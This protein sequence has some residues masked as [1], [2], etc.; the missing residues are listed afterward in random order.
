MRFKKFQLAMFILTVFFVQ[1]FNYWTFIGNLPEKWILYSWFHQFSKFALCYHLW[2]IL[3]LFLI[4]D[5]RVHC[6]RFLFIQVIFHL[7]L[8]LMFRILRFFFHFLIFHF[9]SFFLWMPLL[10]QFLVFFDFLVLDLDLIFVDFCWFII[11][12]IF[13]F[14]W[15]FG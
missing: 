8:L 3:F 4:F 10:F 13:I 2:S 6:F 7:V 12:S 15:L 11:F 1:Y 5:F 14:Y 9:L